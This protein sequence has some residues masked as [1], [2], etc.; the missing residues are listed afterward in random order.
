MEKITYKLYE[1]L[2]ETRNQENK[3]PCKEIIEMDL[4]RMDFKIDD[5][6][7]THIKQEIK[8]C[9][10]LFQLYRPDIG[11]VQGMSYF[12]WMILIR[13]KSYQAFV[14]FSNIILHDPFINA[15]YMFKREKI[16]SIINFYLECLEDKKPKLSKHMIKL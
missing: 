6:K 12:A 10:E 7:K 5:E 3:L 2:S 4:R 9:L 11:Y 8:K 14:C 13:M 15:L 16:N 1:I